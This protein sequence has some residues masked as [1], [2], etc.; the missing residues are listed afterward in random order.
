M[1]GCESAK[2]GETSEAEFTSFAPEELHLPCHL[3][4]EEGSHVEPSSFPGRFHW[5]RASIAGETSPR[6]DGAP[7]SNVGA[8]PAMYAFFV[9]RRFTMLKRTP[10]RNRSDRL[11]WGGIL[12]LTEANA[13][14]DRVETFR[15]ALQFGTALRLRLL[16]TI[17]SGPSMFATALPERLRHDRSMFISS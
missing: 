17:Y 13:E 7:I 3:A 1:S 5:R 4:R 2:H 6:T 8:R 11:A 16:A 12:A 14:C 9:Q 10:G 15:G